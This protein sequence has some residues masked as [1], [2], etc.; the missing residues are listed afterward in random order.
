MSLKNNFKIVRFFFCFCLFECIFLCVLN[1]YEDNYFGISD[2]Q[3]GFFSSGGF[4]S[5]EGQK[6]RGGYTNLFG[7]L[8][9]GID[10]YGF[11]FKIGGSAIALLHKVKNNDMYSNVSDN[12]NN[13]SFRINNDE[14]KDFRYTSDTFILHTLYMSYKNSWGALIAGRFPLKLEWIGDYIEGISVGIDRFEDWKI[15]AGWFD[16]QAYGDPQENVHFGYIKNLYEKYENYKIKNN[17]FLDIKYTN[18]FLNLNIYYNYFD[19]LFDSL[20]IK[21]DWN[22]EYKDFRFG[23]LFHYVFVSSSSQSPNTCLD[24]FMANNVG[25]ACYV[26]GTMGSVL[27]YLL[28]LEQSLN[29]KNWHFSIGYLQNDNR[30]TT[31][32]LPIYSDNN[33][34]EYNTV[35]YGG[36]AKTGYATFRYEWEKRYFLSFKYG[37][38]HYYSGHQWLFQDQFN[39]LA[40]VD[41]SHINVSVGY[42][43]I[44]DGGGYKNNIARIWLGF[45]F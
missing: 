43:N 18:I 24:P 44:N 34:L 22:F 29:F 41:F 11:D 1:A 23:T 33:P 7:S 31:N 32:N 30:G 12:E 37:L 19:T 15:Q 6:L 5:D 10:I 8:S 36:G 16:A 38:S 42:F 20:G 13:I 28:Q 14:A 3:V 40:G 25:L 39:A 2:A 9:V 35:V 26:E 27:G 45:K 4:G 17:Y 21:T